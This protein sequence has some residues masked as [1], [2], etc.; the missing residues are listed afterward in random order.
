M[1]AGGY[2][3]HCGGAQG[4]HEAAGRIA[5]LDNARAVAAGHPSVLEWLAVGSA[6]CN[7][8]HQSKIQITQ[9]GQKCG[10]LGR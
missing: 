6:W 3:V 1:V 4:L 7:I 2:F 5:Y 10:R 9:G 8:L